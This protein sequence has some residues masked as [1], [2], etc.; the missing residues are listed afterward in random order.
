MGRTVLV[1]GATPGSLGHATAVALAAAGD[2]V[3]VTA[4]SRVP[5]VVA[6]CGAKAGSS[7]AW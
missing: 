7:A 5:E 4:R 1:T 6:A 2:E 3:V